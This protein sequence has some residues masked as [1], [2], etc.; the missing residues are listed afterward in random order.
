MSEQTTPEPTA[1]PAPE[2]KRTYARRK[3]LA[4]P[5]PPVSLNPEVAA[6]AAVHAAL[7]PLTGNGLALDRVL[8]WAVSYFTDNG[9]VL[10][11]EVPVPAVVPPVVRTLDPLPDAPEEGPRLTV[12]EWLDGEFSSIVLEDGVGF[13]RV[14]EHLTMP[15]HEFL[16]LLNRCKYSVADLPVRQSPPANPFLAGE[17][18]TGERGDGELWG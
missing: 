3:A 7:E 5:A 2:P 9:T 6:M 15:R 13:Q 16:T 12:G 17:S 18:Q 10:A 8:R 1:E 11:S 4:A 14:P